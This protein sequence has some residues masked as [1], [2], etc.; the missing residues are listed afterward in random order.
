MKTYYTNEVRF[1]IPSR[2]VDRTVNAFVVPAG[3]SGDPI[4]PDA[5]GEFSLVVTRAPLPPGLSLPAYL[6][7]QIASVAEM[8]PDFHLLSRQSATVDN[9]PAE[10]VDFSWRSEEAPMRQQQTHFLHG[11]LVV[12]VTGTA[13]DALFAKHRP[14]LEQALLTMKMN[15]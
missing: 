6:D 9:Q 10:Q 15:A 4:D 1:V 12:S 3:G 5:P 7:R 11:S 14:V 8:L 2:S 13:T